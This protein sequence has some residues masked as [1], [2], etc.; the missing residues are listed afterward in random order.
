M[1]LDDL[2]FGTRGR[3]EKK[4][5]VR[6]RTRR[7]PMS[8]SRL[9]MHIEEADKDQDYHYAWINDSNGLLQRAHQAGFE[10][11]TR[12]DF[13][14]WGEQQIDMGDGSGQLVAMQVGG[15]IT[16]YFMKQPMEYYLED[17]AELDAMV[18]AKEADLKRTLAQEEGIYGDLDIK[19]GR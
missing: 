15:G 11:C 16:A 10:H 5:E 9:R 6:E 2:S 4:S 12:K 1:A 14:F 18:D 13:P 8:G 19:K 7:V 3:S 17:R